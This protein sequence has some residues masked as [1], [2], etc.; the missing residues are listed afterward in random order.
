MTAPSFPST[1]TVVIFSKDRPLQLDAALR[2]WSRHCQDAASSVV[3]VLYKASTARMLSFY[4]RLMQ[5]H[6]GVDFVRE[7][8]F[9][10]DL[11]VLLA[12]QQYVGFVVDDSIFV[13]DFS[14][15]GIA[16]A[17]DRHPEAIGFSLRLGRNTTYCYMLNRAQS[18]PGFEATTQSALKYRWPDAACDF[19]Y[20]LE[21]SSSVYRGEQILPLLKQIE[22]KNPNTLEEA[23]SQKTAR[24][25]QSHP[26]LLC[27]ENS[28]AFAVPVNR[29]QEEVQTNRAGANPGFSA[30]ALAALF[31][32][33]RRIDT[34][35]LDGFAPRGCHQE[36]EF[37]IAPAAEPVPLVTVIVPCYNQAQYLPEAVASVAAQTLADLEIIIVNDGSPDDTSQVARGLMKKYAGRR[38]RLLEKKNGGLA[39]ARNAGIRSAAGAY[40][41]P[42]DADDR[43]EPAM[44]ERTAALLEENP[45]MA[46]AYTDV[47]H[48][49]VVQKTIQ[50]AEYDFKKLCLGNQ[51]NYCSLYRWEA[52][53][54]AGGYNPNM[55]WGYEDWNFW[56]SCGERGLRAQRIPGALLQYRVKDASMYTA[57]A[58]NDKALRARI[59]LNHPDLY[60]APEVSAARAIWSQP[61]MPDPPAAPKV[62]VVMPTRNRPGFLARALQ[63]VL[64]QTLQDFEILV[65]NDRGIDVSGVIA[66][67]SSRA[68]II[69]LAEP[70]GKGIA[71]A[72]N[73]GMRAASGKYIAH[74][75][76]DDLFHPNH[77]ETLVSF[78]ENSGQK[79]AYT[80]AW[81]AEEALADGQYKVV[82]RELSYSADWDHDRILVQNFVP[83]LCF[84]HERRSGIAAGDFDEQLSTH[85]DWDFWI[86]L[87][88]V[89]TPVHIKKVTCE[90][91]KRTDGSSMTSGHRP[92]FLRTI[93]MV[94]KKHQAHA[95]GNAT[96]RRQQKQFLRGLEKELGAPRPGLSALLRRIFRRREQ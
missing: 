60:N 58:A 30:D 31:A 49:G 42:L 84:M 17:L 8:D 24:F 72:R 51:L 19:G 90:F 55:I 4:R 56:I 40:I 83:T 53:E 79:A 82:R 80:D 70:A 91:R 89:C 78:L 59:V 69:Y 62:S 48:F 3:K 74:L 18:L 6:P 15:A 46:I 12:H 13:R 68:R 95:A 35:A 9:R 20:P 32:L 75:D 16:S 57:A 76:D 39:G 96:I 63:S 71:A 54:R 85:E 26:F 22:F 67:F 11:L 44:L 28:L 29:V 86:R 38:I 65:A 94:Y 87:S 25:R 88:R 2:S 41:L 5:E 81:C 27:P 1:W 37:K 47:S 77:L 45:G 93:Q 7:G 34:A 73:S 50:A 52:W 14:L 43:I 92:D 61:A 33:G 10:S 36:V 23:L 66:R 64:D 21:V